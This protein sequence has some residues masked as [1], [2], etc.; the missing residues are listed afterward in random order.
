MS[1]LLGMNGSNV[2]VLQEWTYVNACSRHV[3]AIFHLIFAEPGKV[4]LAH[5]CKSAFFS[6]MII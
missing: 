4:I 5:P 6:I 2:S 3:T 1:E